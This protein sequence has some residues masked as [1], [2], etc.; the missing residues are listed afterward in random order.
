MIEVDFDFF[1]L[2]ASIS[3][4]GNSHNTS[5]YIVVPTSQKHLFHT[6]CFT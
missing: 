3:S 2:A 6:D 1:S 4:V 5:H